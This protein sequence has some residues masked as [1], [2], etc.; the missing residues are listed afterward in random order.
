MIHLLP[1]DLLNN[2]TAMYQPDSRSP[3][4]P[5]RL[6]WFGF[7]IYSLLVGLHA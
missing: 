2:W 3:T 6:L 1:G 4:T 7:N 5:L